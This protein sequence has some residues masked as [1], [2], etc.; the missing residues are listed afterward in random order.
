MALGQG[1]LRRWNFQRQPALCRACRWHGLHRSLP[2]RL[3]PVP[4]VQRLAGA[5]PGWA[6]PTDQHQLFARRGERPANR[7]PVL[8]HPAGFPHQPAA[9]RPRLAT[10]EICLP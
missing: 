5:D 4:L 8:R 3:E 1:R 7:L 10:G 9:S 2:G 6:G